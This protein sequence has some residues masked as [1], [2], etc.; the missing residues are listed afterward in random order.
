MD[1]VLRYTAKAM[2]EHGIKWGSKTLLKSNY[3]DDLSFLD[4]GVIKMNELLEVLRVQGKRIV[5]KTNLKKTFLL[6]L[7][8]RKDEKVV[9]GN[10]KID[11]SDNFTYLGSI[12]IHSSN[13]FER[14]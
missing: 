2:G 1:F 13:K 11:Q 3:A 8:I 10:E 7:E 6:R 9:L 14:I 12:I 5:L 4:E